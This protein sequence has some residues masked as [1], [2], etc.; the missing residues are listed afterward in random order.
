MPVEPKEY[1]H[2]PAAY[3]NAIADEGTKAEAIEWLQKTWNELCW[4]RAY[5]L[6][7]RE[8]EGWK[9]VPMEPTIEMENAGD[10][11]DRDYSNNRFAGLGSLGRSAFIYHHMLAAAPPAEDGKEKLTLTYPPEPPSW[12]AIKGDKPTVVVEKSAH[13]DLRARYAALVESNHSAL[14]RG[15]R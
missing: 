2:V 13:D 9:C 15:D 6:S 8:R 5:A 7:L 11:A 12:V 3:I 4:V 14:A 10:K 1:P